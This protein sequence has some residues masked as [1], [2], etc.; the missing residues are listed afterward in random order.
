MAEKKET[1]KQVVI[2]LTDEQRQQIKK[3]TGKL[4]TELK[5]EVVEDRANP[6]VNPWGSD[7]HPH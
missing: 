6:T 1:P 2:T 5:V 7:I 4:V 3:A